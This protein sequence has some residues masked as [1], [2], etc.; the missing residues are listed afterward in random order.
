MRMAW[1]ADYDDPMTFL[2]LMQSKTGQQNYGDYASPAYDALIAAADHEPDEAR[3]A[4]LLVR[5]ERIMLD[6]APVAP[7]Y[8]TVSRNLVSPRLSGWVDNPV[9]A[10]RARYLCPRPGGTVSGPGAPGPRVG[11]SPS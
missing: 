5:A 4:D 10:H 11:R 6:D 8:F 9:D 1:I 2:Y 3:R 7:L